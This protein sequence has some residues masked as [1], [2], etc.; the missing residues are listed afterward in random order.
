MTA[1]DMHVPHGVRWQRHLGSR[2]TWRTSQLPAENARCST[3]LAYSIMQH[4]APSRGISSHSRLPST[5]F[6][7]GHCQIRL[8][9][10][11]RTA[12]CGRMH[13]DTPP[14]CWI[15]TRCET[16]GARMHSSVPTGLLPV[17]LLRESAEAKPKR[18]CS[19]ERL[20]DNWAI[21]AQRFFNSCLPHPF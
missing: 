20:A 19:A 2:R 21:G 16:P 9:A 12:I 17:N 7:I 1:N 10:S 13:V 6:P 15:Y 4:S 5:L 8:C 18:A 14:T 11:V 3:V